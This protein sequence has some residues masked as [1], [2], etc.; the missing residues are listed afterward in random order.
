MQIFSSELVTVVPPKSAILKQNTS[1]V[2][3]II[4]SSVCI[5][6]QNLL[7]CYLFDWNKWRKEISA[8]SL[9]SVKKH[10]TLICFNGQRYP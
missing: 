2:L 8:I 5:V 6:M 7:H 4:C 1:H 3:E 9:F 10:F